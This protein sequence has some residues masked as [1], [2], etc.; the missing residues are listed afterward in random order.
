[1]LLQSLV[2]YYEILAGKENSDIPK[3]G[4]SKAKVSYALTISQEGELVGIMPLK[5]SDASGKKQIALEMEVPEQVKRTVGVAANFLC[6]NSSYVLGFDNKGNEKRSK[7]CYDTFKRLNQTILNNVNSDAAKAIY[8]FLEKWEV[9]KAIKNPILTEYLDDIY[10][11]A[12]F[13]FR[14]DGKTTFIHQENNI[15]RAWE[16]YKDESADCDT[17][18]CLVTGKDAKIAV[19]HPSIRGIW[20]GQP[21]G[22]T[23][24]SFN[25]P[26]YESYGNIKA[27]GLNAPVSEYAAFAYSTALNFMLADTGHRMLLGDSTIVFWAECEDNKGY[28]DIFSLMNNPDELVQLQKGEQTYIRDSAAVEDVKS[29]FTKVANGTMVSRN[30]SLNEDTKFYVLALSP[31]AARISIRF[32]L[33]NN[34]GIF[35]DMLMKHYTDLGMEKQ[36]ERDPD[37][38]SIWRLLNETVAPSSTDKAASPILTGSVLRSVLTGCAYPLGLFQSIMIRIR[39]EKEI[40]YVKAAIIKAYLIRCT[41][42]QA[43]KKEGVLEMSLNTQSENKAYVLGRLFAAL[44]K[45]QKDANPG[46]NT[47]IKDR[48]F[49]SACANP[50]QTFPVLLKLSNY[51][52]SKAEYGFRNENNIEEIMQLFKVEEAPFPRSL[53]LE[54]QGIFVL[55]YYHQRNKFFTDMKVASELKKEKEKNN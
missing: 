40:T 46:I 19:L 13:V 44:E 24:V 55:G 41:H 28:Q 18:R 1:M 14:L 53:S 50:A 6:D 30:F 42:A 7:E 10:K 22:N 29:F 5:R 4:Y 2:N 38:I 11:G 16:A 8:C 26:A 45:A 33:Y 20:G 47:T 54:N 39:A 49:T 35:M 25:A 3:L 15:K 51:H 43:Y 12:N 9:E 37:S 21:M 32:M 48:Y 34:F 23:L 17:R 52:I 36:F 31:N 27:Q